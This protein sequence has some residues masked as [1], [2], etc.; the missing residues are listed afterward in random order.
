MGIGLA[1]VKQIAELHEGRVQADSAG[2]DRGARFTVSMPLY[3]PGVDELGSEKVGASGALR[4]KFILVVDDSSESSE[5]LGKLLEI[6]GAFVDLA[7]SGAEALEIANKK[8]F[9]LVI[10]DISMPE[11]DGYQLLRELRE[12][13][14]MGSVPAV[15]LTGYGRPADI[16]RAHEEGFAEHLIKP[17]D[18][19]QLLPIVRRL[20]GEN[21]GENRNS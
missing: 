9:D 18:I 12:L 4:S 15:A 19:D 20:T 7:R 8:R 13:P 21:G 2:V 3:K 17:I 5:M 16:E 1:L 10:S 6:E 11:M 14:N